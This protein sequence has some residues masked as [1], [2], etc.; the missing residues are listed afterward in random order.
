MWTHRWGQVNS[1]GAGHEGVVAFLDHLPKQLNHGEGQTLVGRPLP[2]E[3]DG[4][5]DH[6]ETEGDE[7]GNK[8][9]LLG[10]KPSTFESRM[11]K[12]GI[13][14]ETPR[15]SKILRHCEHPLLSTAPRPIDRECPQC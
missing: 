1:R 15:K 3:D 12:L 5:E 8:A 13:S 9:E 7:E 10:L 14:R 11:R 2:V 6:H 4:H